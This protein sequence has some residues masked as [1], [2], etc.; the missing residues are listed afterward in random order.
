MAE[1]AVW[2]KDEALR[3]ACWWQLQSHSEL[4]GSL[5]KRR[6]A[7]LRVHQPSR[8]WRLCVCCFF[9]RPPSASII[10]PLCPFHCH[11]MAWSTTLVMPPA[12]SFVLLQTVIVTRFLVLVSAGL[13]LAWLAS[14]GYLVNLPSAAIDNSATELVLLA[15]APRSTF[16]FR[17][18]VRPPSVIAR[19]LWVLLRWDALALARAFLSQHTLW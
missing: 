12:C 2:L 10:C 16:G 14:A 4:L 17:M 6:V 19:W 3:R 13:V 18:W 15:Q 8:L 5:G 11:A 7:S 9:V 1:M